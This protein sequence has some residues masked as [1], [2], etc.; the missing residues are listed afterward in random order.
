MKYVEVRSGDTIWDVV[1]AMKNNCTV[2]F[3]LGSY[4]RADGYFEVIEDH[5]DPEEDHYD[6]DE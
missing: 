5:Y 2:L 6:E 3:P 4:L 1:T